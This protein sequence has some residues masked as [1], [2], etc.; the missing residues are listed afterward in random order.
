MQKQLSLSLVEFAFVRDLEETKEMK[1]QKPSRAFPNN[2]ESC[3][4]R[5]QNLSVGRWVLPSLGY[6]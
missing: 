4:S 3:Q 6:F 1:K 5:S 2:K